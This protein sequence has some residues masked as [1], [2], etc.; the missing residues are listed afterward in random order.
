MP[1][2]SD[3]SPESA[4]RADR[5][6]GLFGLA[7]GAGFAVMVLEIAGARV[8]APVF[9]LSAV[10]WTAVIGVVLSALALGNHFGGRLADEG[11]LPLAWILSAAGVAAVVPVMGGGIPGWSVSVFGFVAGAVV[12]A[13]VLFAPPV[14]CLGAVVPYLVRAGTR[15]LDRVGRR[16][17]DVSAAATLGSIAGTFLT[18]F[19]LLPA[20]PLPLLL[21]LTAAGLF[22]LAVLSALVLQRGP[23]TGA[24]ALAAVLAGG[25]GAVG[26]GDAVG[27]LHREET[28][29]GSIQVTER[30]WSDGRAVR[31]LW[32]NG[33]SSS[34]EEVLTGEAAHAYIHASLEVLEPRLPDVDSALV[35]GGAALSLPVELVRRNSGVAVDVVE[36]DP[37][38]TRLAEEYFAYGRLEEDDRIRVVHDDARRFLE[39]ARG[40]WDLIYLDVFDHLVTVPWTV[41]TVEAL[42]AVE[43]R[44]A[45]GGIVMANVLSPLEGPG[46]DFLRR[47]LATWGETFP[48][49]RAYVVPPD[50]GGGPPPHD[51]GG[52]S[53][54]DP[55]ATRNVLLVAARDP[56]VLSGPALLRV[57]VAAQGPPL[58]DRWAPVEYLQAKLFVEGL[59]WR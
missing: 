8:M 7:F 46:A 59:R 9:G 40:R 4:E 44:L 21:G 24:L 18:G 15:R 10:P 17:G 36:L 31:E 54:G 13:A 56:G 39:R 20:L 47:L 55:G 49:V 11:R 43:T 19:V 45:P 27:V 58:T 29:Y 48:E 38:V 22:G 5:R 23:S 32:Q 16:A 52:V 35:L 14:L 37:A 51:A 3:A 34:A 57:P 1:L 53:E 30:E 26:P 25:L 33:G 6:A 12:S 41:V 28:V 42:E 2:D 50:D